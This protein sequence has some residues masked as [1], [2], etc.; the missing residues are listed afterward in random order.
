MGDYITPYVPTA[1]DALNLIK[2][3]YGPIKNNRVKCDM[4]HHHLVTVTRFVTED[5]IKYKG[6]VHGRIT[7]CEKPNSGKCIMI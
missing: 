5:G 4:K 2:D 1:K 6:L 3:K 7:R